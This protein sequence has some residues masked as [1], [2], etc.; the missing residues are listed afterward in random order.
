MKSV[1]ARI[2]EFNKGLLPDKVSWKYQCMTENLFRFYRGINPVFYEDLFKDREAIPHSP[3]T[4][5]CGDLHVENFGSYK[6]DNGLTYFDLNDFDDSILA[7]VA[8]ELVRM[9]TGIFVAF[10]ALKIK[11][12]KAM[13]MAALF[14]KTYSDTLAKGKAQYI[15]PKTAKGIVCT[16]L[17]HAAK[18]R[19]T[20]LISKKAVR[21]KNKLQLRIDGEKHMKL[22]KPLRLK[23]EKH[24]Q[25]WILQNNDGP[26]HYR[27]RD[28]IFRV[29]GTGSLG[30]KR[31]LFLLQSTLQK[32]NYLFL[33][34]K[35]A[36]PSCLR[37]YIRIKQPEWKSDADR[38]VSV[39]E[40][41]Q[42]K[43]AALVSSTLFEG[44]SY[45]LEEMQPTSDKINFQLIK[46]RYRDVYQVIDDMALL[47][48]SAQL[49]S[50]G[51]HGSAIADKM[52]EFGNKTSWQQPLLDYSAAYAKKVKQYYREFVNDY[53]K[54]QIK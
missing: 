43:G 29:A 4:W 42:S 7:P 53:K 30:V 27:V 35:Q 31:Y 39:A 15:E 41:M 22:E 9:L 36:T 51:R 12:D 3:Q 23:L 21:H 26:Y 54:G 8:W 2:R 50:S 37:P 49:R 1:T 44:D 14:L 20:D 38:V 47:T 13:R 17:S 32:K 5:I 40:R 16:F 46:D 33:D 28:V 6:A 34:M 18:R 19:Q 24:L 25:K 10:D 48:A 45:V 11:Q 52:M